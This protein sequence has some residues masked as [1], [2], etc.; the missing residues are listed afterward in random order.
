MSKKKAYNR[1]PFMRFVFLVYL[2]AMLWLLFGRSRW[3]S[4]DM[5]YEE[6]LRTNVNFTP[7]L[8]IR[9]YWQVV[10]HRTNDAYYS[11]CLI[12]LL[13]NV[14]L[15]IPAGWMIPGIW[16]GHRNFFQFFASCLAAIL[17][18]ELTQLLTGLGSFDIDDVILNM[19]GLLLGY[20]AY[21]LTH[22]RKK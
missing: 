12:N 11:H 13:G 10:F 14:L 6:M 7:F 9:N 19:S 15:F 22:L 17:I 18:I 2:A 21:I 1:H 3:N 8:T 20:L 4:Q 16:S 5:S